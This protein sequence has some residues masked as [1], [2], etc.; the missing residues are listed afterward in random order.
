M[1]PSSKQWRRRSPRS[2]LLTSPDGSIIAATRS[3]FS[4]YE[5]RCKLRKQRLGVLEVARN[6]D[7]IRLKRRIELLEHDGA[8]DGVIEPRVLVLLR[9]SPHQAVANEWHPKVFGQIICYGITHTTCV[10]KQR[11]PDRLPRS[12]VAQPQPIVPEHIMNALC[13]IRVVGVEGQLL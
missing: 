2:P 8:R 11:G 1:K 10:N 5:Y 13:N 12:A 6:P 4:T 3:R 9:R 7:A